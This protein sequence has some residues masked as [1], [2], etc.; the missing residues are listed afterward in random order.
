MPDLQDT[1]ETVK[2]RLREM[3]VDRARSLL[4]VLGVVWGTLSLAVVFAFG[5]G[6]QQA[7]ETALRA[8]GRDYLRLWSGATTRSHAGLPAG[9]WI[10]LQPEDADRIAAGVP[11]VRGVS[12][13]FIAGNQTM[14]YAGKR[15]N[16][17]IH[18]VNAG[19]GELRSLEPAAG[20][21]F[22]NSQDDA[23]RRRVVFLGDAIKRRLFGETPAIG[24]AIELWGRPFTVVGVMLPKVAMS[25][26]EW[27]DEEKVFIPART[28]V[29]LTGRQFVNYLIVGL[30]R[31]DDDERVLGRTRKL[32]ARRNGFDA[33]DLPA[34]GV[35]NQV[36]TDRVTRGIVTG[37]R[38]LLVIVGTLGLLVALVGVANVL[39]VMVEEQR[40]E[41]GLLM[42]LG[43]T[44]RTVLFGPLLD[45]ALL[46]LSA[47]LVGIVGSVMALALFN[48]LPLGREPR[49]YLGSPTV[50]AGIALGL[51]A[52]LCLAAVAAAWFP[53]RQ[54]ARANPVESLREE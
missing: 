1:L 42:A 38:S 36:A 15:L 39:F 20:G 13:E 35:Q 26:Y 47:G 8:S 31:A 53:A 44:P 14:A 37:I 23:Q 5:N 49:A 34:V 48:A 7:I 51:T 11:G 22:L 17:A 45:G 40:A 18:G 25:S 9:R 50:S 41:I 12:V 16:A 46:T 10:G 29:A 2:Q 54:A 24:S 21:R 4:V 6:L 3:A 28:F 27:K 52:T 19:F 30:D 32:L 43:A 33:G